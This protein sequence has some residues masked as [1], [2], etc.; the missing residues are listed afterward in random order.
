VHVT[1]DAGAGGLQGSWSLRALKTDYP[2]RWVGFF[3]GVALAAGGDYNS[4]VGGIHSSRDYG[5][6]WVLDLDTGVEM[7]AC[8]GTA[9]DYHAHDDDDDDGVVDDAQ[10]GVRRHS[11]PSNGGG[12]GRHSNRSGGGS[13]VVTCVGSAKGKASVIVSTLLMIGQQ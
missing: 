6:T 1:A 7:S 2:I 9:R 4:G 10:D 8:A 11:R 13:V 5:K 12:G 3:A